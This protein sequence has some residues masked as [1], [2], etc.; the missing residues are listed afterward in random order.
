M[1]SKM[2][3]VVGVPEIAQKLGKSPKKVRE[4]LKERERFLRENGHRRADLFLRRKGRGKGYRIET[5]WSALEEFYPELFEGG[6]RSRFE[7]RLTATER[8]E[9]ELLDAVAELSRLPELVQRLTAR[10]EK[11]E[12]CVEK[13]QAE[14]SRRKK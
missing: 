13:L 1:T 8:R 6:P 14:L 12:K 9:E 2:S 10:V 3:E 7:E 11:L 4:L 5:T